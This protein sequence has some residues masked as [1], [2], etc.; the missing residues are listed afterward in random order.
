MAVDLV[1]ETKAADGLAPVDLDAFWTDQEAA[2]PDP[3]AARRVPI[4][5]LWS[6]ECIFDELGLTEDW[7]RYYHDPAWVLEQSVRYNDRAEAIVGRRL[8]S[9]AAAPAEPWPHPRGLNELFEAENAFLH[10]SFWLKQSADNEGEL[11]AL[12]DRVEQRLADPRSFFYGPD[13]DAYCRRALDAGSEPMVYHHQRGPVTFATSVFGV[14]NFCYLFYDHP[15]LMR[16]FSDCI[17]SA[18]LAMRQLSE[19]L[20]LRHG[21][22]VEPGFNF[23]DDNCYLLTPEQYEFFAAPILQALFD[24]C[25]PRPEDLRYQHSDSSMGHLLP[26]LAQFQLSQV[27]FGPDVPAAAIRRHM[28]DT[29]IQG[30]LAP[31]TYSRHDEVGMV[32][33]FLR[34]MDQLRASRGLLFATAGSVNNGSRLHGLRLIMAAV[35]RWG[36]Y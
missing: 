15:Q 12:L 20:C 14:E 34:D 31:F 18:M 27:N 28:P 19:E 17:R 29:I 10:D 5:T 22:K 9:E 23:Y 21:C 36:W 16:R 4:D 13:V 26:T 35:Q 11:A 32:N 1:A 33:E 24:H 3:F 2:R 7:Y 6:S 8:L 30:Q 25:S